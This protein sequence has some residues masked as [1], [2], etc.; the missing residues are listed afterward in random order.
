MIFVVRLLFVFLVNMVCLMMSLWD[1][2]FII[3]KKCGMF[4]D[5]VRLM[6]GIFGGIGKLVL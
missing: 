3:L 4:G 5:M 2:V 6:I 1:S